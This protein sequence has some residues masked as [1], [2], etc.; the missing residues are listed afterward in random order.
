VDGGSRFSSS[1]PLFSFC[2]RPVSPS[3]PQ[4]DHDRGGPFAAVLSGTANAVGDTVTGITQGGQL[5]DQN[6]QLRGQLA[7]ALAENA[8]LQQDARENRQFRTLLRF[9]TANPRMDFLTARVIGSDP[10]GVLSPSL[11][12]NKGSRDHLRNG[13]TVVSDRGYFVGTIYELN[14]TSSKVLLMI[15]PSSSVGALDLRTNAAGL[16]EGKYAGFPVLDAVV[17]SAM[18]HVHDF[19]VTSGQMN[20]FPRTILLGQITAIRRSNDAM[21]QT[22]EIQPMAD[23]SNLEDVQVIRSFVPSVSA[24]LLGPH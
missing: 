24:K 12:I 3:G 21:F 19:V 22:A 20:L 8:V 7:R 14:S 17:T 6:V 23:F 10:N 2:F 13:M 18:L 4:C 11:I 9:D 5:R 15:N 16:V 1:S